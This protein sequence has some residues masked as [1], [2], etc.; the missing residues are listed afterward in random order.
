MEIIPV[1]DCMGGIVV[2][3]CGGC[4]Q[5][6]PP[7]QSIV[8]KHTDP[9]KV[10]ADLKS[11]HP[12]NAIYLADLDAIC[13]KTMNLAFYQQLV[14]LFP[15]LVF[16]LDAG[17]KVQRDWQ[18]L[19]EII[20]IEP[21]IASESLQHLDL[22]TLAKQ[23]IL[24]LDFKGDEFVGDPAL[25][26]QANRWPDNVIV[27]NLDS[28]GSQAGPDTEMLQKIQRTR[29]DVNVIAAGG[30]RNQQDLTILSEM[31]INSALVASALH[32]GNLEFGAMNQN[33][34]RP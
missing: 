2:Q 12:F 13:H 8:T 23:G 18:I 33:K 20:G 27:M 1:I 9:M 3:A 24:S 25:L 4:R 21:V 16:C 19:S 6:Y 17:I 7:L 31:G 22:L 11:I 30:V 14:R 28:V 34:H 32:N 15:D 26:Q 29:S 5:N 10:I